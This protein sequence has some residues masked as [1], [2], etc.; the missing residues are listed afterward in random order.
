VNER[1]PTRLTDTELERRKPVWTAFSE[2]WLDTELD[3]NDLQRIARI[4]QASGYAIAE[5]RDIYLYEVAPVVSP[6]LLTV[7]G[8][9]D[10]FDEQWLH[11]ACR[12]RAEHRS[13]WLRFW[14]FIGIGR[15]L[16][17]FITERHWRRV[18][19][20]L[21]VANESPHGNP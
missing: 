10:G 16:M 20:L 5:L 17:T 13:L 2:L 18:V 4:V 11:T 19:S 1:N 3:D 7:A 8:E 9:W 21:P 15:M 14:V 12:K 6:N